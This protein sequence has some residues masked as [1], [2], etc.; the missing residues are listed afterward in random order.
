MSWKPPLAVYHNGEI[1]GYNVTL[2]TT[3]LAIEKTIFSAYNSTTIWSL[4]PYTNYGITV[5]AITRAGIGPY[6][7]IITFTTD[8]SGI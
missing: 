6:S 5:A 7:T 3:N 4:D 1:I 8:E 2:I